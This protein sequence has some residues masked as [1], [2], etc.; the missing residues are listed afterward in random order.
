MNTAKPSSPG[1]EIY[2]GLLLCQKEVY[3]SYRK[4]GYLEQCYYIIKYKLQQVFRR[5]KDNAK[6]T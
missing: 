3:M 6:K 5:R 1:G 2:A 4:V